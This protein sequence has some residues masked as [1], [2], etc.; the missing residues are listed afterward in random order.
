MEHFPEFVANHLFL[1]TLLIAILALL[2]WSFLGSNVGGIP[3]VGPAEATRL[4]NREN[5][6]MLDV[7][8]LDD[9][10]QGHII[11]AL[12]LP[13][14]ETETASKKFDKYKQKPVII[15]CNTGM[16]SVRVARTLK[17]EGFENLY[18][19]KGGMQSW[20]NANLPVTRE[21][22]EKESA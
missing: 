15:Y 2:I 14:S 21:E 5:A 20:R 16:E 17:N 19:L 11:N 9:F 1:F 18:I 7:R 3:Q 22:S 4:V 13:A 6:R 12:N 10:N 8:P